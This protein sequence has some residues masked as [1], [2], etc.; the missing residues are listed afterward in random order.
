MRRFDAT[1]AT[2][3]LASFLQGLPPG[4]HVAVDL[5]DLSMDTAVDISRQVAR[6]RGERFVIVAH[7]GSADNEVVSGSLAEALP[8]ESFA[9]PHNKAWVVV[10]AEASM[11]AESP[12]SHA[13][14]EADLGVDVAPRLTVVCFYTPVA[15]AQVKPKDVHRLHS[16][17]AA[18][19]QV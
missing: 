11:A 12:T 5:G 15:L 8:L 2:E 13:D 9:A 6:E 14:A 3:E 17:V 7:R 1:P 10:D 19:R 18:P 4:S 16:V